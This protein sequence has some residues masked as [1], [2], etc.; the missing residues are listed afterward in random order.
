LIKYRCLHCDGLLCETSTCPVCGSRTVLDSST[1]FYCH[2]CNAPSYSEICPIC[3]NKCEPI[4]TDLRPVFSQERLLIECL[5][6][7]PMKYA[8]KSIWNACNN[9]YLIDGIKHRVSFSDFEKKA[10]EEIIELLKKYENSNYSFVKADLNNK[11]L[12]A[13]VNINRVHLNSITDEALDYIKR[14]SKGFDEA[15]MF[16]SFSCGKDSTVTSNL[17]MRALETEKIIHI[18]GDTTLEYPESETYLNIFRKKYPF[19]PILVAKNKDQKFTDLC[20]VVGPPSRVMRWCCTVFKTG[21]ITKKIEQTFKNKNRI[22]SF[23]GIRRNESLSRS[24][25]DRDST[26]SKITKQLASSPIIDWLDFDVWLYLLSNQIP[27]NSA[28][29]QGFSRVGCWCC[30]NNS[31][32]SEYLSSIYM[33][34]EYTDFHQILYSFAKKVGKKDWKEYIDTGKWK[35]RQGGNGL[36]YSKNSVVEFKP[37]VLDEN[38]YNFDLTRPI[39]QNLYTLFKPFGIIN[40]D[41]GNKRL[42]EIYIMDKKSGLPLL[43]LSGRIGTTA[44]RITVI[45]HIGCFKYSKL[46]ESLIKNQITK[47]QTCIGCTYC[48]SVCRFNALTV[49]NTKP[50]NVSHDSIMYSIDSKKCLGCLECVTHFDG[51]CY[52]KKVLR[53]KKGEN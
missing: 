49:T 27:F 2:N 34:K 18:Y 33:N 40:E 31:D 7:S 53:L 30:P 36:E 44:L 38:S 51:G 8:G 13:F 50:G 52:M 24:K 5:E 17:V 1:I 48:Q 45:N 23:Q 3:H 9:T 35:A 43:K 15:S 37:C 41:L 11:N 14:I 12:D 10:Q 22:L 16:I 32:W 39:T 19:T 26:N 6:G 21:A 47:Y 42:N 20:Q 29:R 28:Y 46:S 25:Y 4:G